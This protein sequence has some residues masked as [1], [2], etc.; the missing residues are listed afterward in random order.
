MS[1]EEYRKLARESIQEHSRRPPDEQVLDKLLENVRYVPGTFDDDSVFEGLGEELGK[2]DE[3]AG[4][5]FNRIFYLSTAPS[6]FALI[7]EKLGDHGLHRHE[8]A[9]VR[10]VIEKP[11]GTRESE[12]QELNRQ[13][14]SV[15]KESQ[16]YRIDHYLGKETVQNVLAF[17]FANV[18]FEPVFN[19]SYVDHIQ[20]TAAESIGV[21]GRGGYYEEAGA[22]RDM[23]QSHL[24]QVLTVVTMEPPAF[25]NGNAVRDEKVKVLRSV[26]PPRGECVA[27]RTVRGQYGP[28][29]IGGRPVAGYKE[30][31]GVAPDSQ[32]ETFVAL[33]LGIDNW[34]WAGVP[35]YLRTGKRLP[36]RDTEIAIEFKRVPHL[37]FQSIG[38][39][40]VTPNVLTM[41]IQPDEGITLRFAAKVP[42]AATPDLAYFEG[43]VRSLAR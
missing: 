6:F 21:E 36:R 5:A 15:L 33:R 31:R 34:R 37:M 25:F 13:V 14:L 17:R 38:A 3:D 23:V 9:E 16:V 27:A 19:Q 42:G 35:F 24:L 12:A 43:L 7:V 39:P 22:L 32:T 20:I 18:L 1:S 2:F 10:V 11:F 29:F 40:E 41:R 4:I 26:V 8:D 28:G 30:E